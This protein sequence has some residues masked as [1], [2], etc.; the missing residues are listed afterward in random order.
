MKPEA[1]ETEFVLLMG[2]RGLLL[3]D[4]TAEHG[5]PAMLAYYQEERAEGPSLE[6]DGDMLLYQW[7]TY[8]WGRG[9]FFELDITRQL[10]LNDGEDDDI[11]Q[12]QL[13]FRFSPTASLRDLRRGNRWCS[14]P[15]E[16]AEFETFIRASQAYQ[17]VA[18]V[19]PT[20][21]D[22]RYACAG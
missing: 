8:D 3:R 7:G 13:T 1:A 18:A 2:R 16:L 11:W 9:E 19:K 20:S 14:T 21:V 4:L 10:I 22:L 15:D 17:A 12:L 6:R 5:I